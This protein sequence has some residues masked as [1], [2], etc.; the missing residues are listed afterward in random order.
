LNVP[1]VDLALSLQAT[2]L[3]ETK[4][5]PNQQSS[6]RS[7]KMALNSDQDPSLQHGRHQREKCDR[8]VQQAMDEFGGIN[9]YDVYADVCLPSRSSSPLKRLAA[10]QQGIALQRRFCCLITP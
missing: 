10:R 2:M 7:T 6:R 8:Y 4:K 1:L 9:I 5:P 3:L